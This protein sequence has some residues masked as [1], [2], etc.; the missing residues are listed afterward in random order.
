MLL[1]ILWHMR[2]MDETQTKAKKMQEEQSK[3]L[4]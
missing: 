3:K 4:E 2:V 1:A